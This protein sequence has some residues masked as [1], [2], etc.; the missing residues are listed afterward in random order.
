MPLDEEKLNLIHSKFHSSENIEH[1]L[2]RTHLEKVIYLTGPLMS[3]TESYSSMRAQLL[4]YIEDQFLR[5]IYATSSH[6]E[7]TTDPLTGQSK[8]VKVVELL[9]EKDNQNQFMRIDQSPLDEFGIKAFNVSMNG[10]KYDSKVEEQ[11]SQQQQAIM[12]VQTAIAETKTAEQKTLTVAAKG[13]AEAA[14]A[15]WKQKVMTATA[16]QEAIQKKEVVLTEAA[17]KKE[18]ALTEA[19]QKLEVA[20]LNAQAA[21]QEKLAAIMKGEGEAQARKLVMDADGALGQKLEA[22]VMVNNAYAQAMQGSNWVPQIVFG[23]TST[24][25]GTSGGTTTSNTPGMTQTY[26][27]PNSQVSDFLAMLQVRTAKELTLD[28]KVPEKSGNLPPIK[29][30]DLSKF[31]YNPTT[32]TTSGG[33]GTIHTWSPGPAPSATTTTSTQ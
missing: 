31:K 12:S 23:N 4:A 18:V 6:D 8:T 5:G 25:T 28:F 10:I 7:R 33:A 9:R 1:Q 29:R 19:A 30:P 17:Q 11:I 15:E 13:Q 22:W 3:S 32:T 14:E 27:S 21:E 24:M 2:L 26:S 16:T 20:Q